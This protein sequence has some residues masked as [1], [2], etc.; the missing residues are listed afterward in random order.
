MVNLCSVRPDVEHSRERST[1][2]LQI[3]ALQRTTCRQPGL[4]QP[5]AHQSRGFSA[6]KLTKSRTHPCLP[7]G[8]GPCHLLHKAHVSC[9]PAQLA[10]TAPAPH[11]VLGTKT[12]RAERTCAEVPNNTKKTGTE[13]WGSTNYTLLWLSTIPLSAQNPSCR[14]FPVEAWGRLPDC[15]RR[16]NQLR[17]HNTK[18]RAEAS[19]SES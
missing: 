10:A 16:D 18:P 7:T 5:P 9:W 3:K 17:D 4:T 8:P 14:T 11:K 2:E 6:N 12:T 15:T 1:S 13:P 19:G